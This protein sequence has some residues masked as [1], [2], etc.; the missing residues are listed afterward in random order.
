MVLTSKEIGGEGT[1]LLILHGLFGSSKNWLS[2]GK[3]L[4]EYGEVHL[5]DLR[6]HGDSFHNDSH[7][8][9]DLVEDLKEYIDSKEIQR[10]ILLGHSM[11][12]LAT[13][14]F[15]LLY[16][17]RVVAPIVV[18]IAPRSYPLQY[19]QE[20]AALSMDVS[21]Y[22][23]RQELDSE[24]AEVLPNTF[25]RQFL[26]MNLQRNPSGGYKWKLNVPAL[27]RARDGLSLRV[28]D[29]QSYNDKALFVLGSESSYIND[30]EDIDLILETFPLANIQTIAGAE[31]YLHYTHADEFLK[32]VTGF[33]SDL[34]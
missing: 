32:I 30:P 16:P 26:Q 5:L 33:L 18:D 9:Q 25:I 12:G 6:N 7:R 14:F 1:P 31:H 8:L 17:E 10:A 19:T 2:N 24:M 23:N 13:S 11:G 4:C 3:V 28:D 15:S 22:Q 21:K 34:Q 27:Q 20:F 29:L